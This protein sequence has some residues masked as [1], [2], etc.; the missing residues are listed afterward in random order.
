MDKATKA[1]IKQLIGKLEHIS[2]PQPVRK[3]EAT[4]NTEGESDVETGHSNN[5]IPSTAS[6]PQPQPTKTRYHITYQP[7]KDWWDKNK[8]YVE[9]GGAIL[10]AVYTFFTIKMYCANKQAADAAT[11]AAKTAA[12]ELDLSERPWIYADLA[13]SGQLVFDDPSTQAIATTLRFLVTLRNIGHSVALDVNDW[14]DIIPIPFGNSFDVALNRQRQYCDAV[15]KQNERGGDPLF[16]DQDPLKHLAVTG[17]S[18]IVMDRVRSQ[19]AGREQSMQTVMFIVVGCVDYRSTLNNLHHQT[20]FA[21]V[22]GKH[23]PDPKRPTMIGGFEPHG[24][25]EGLAIGY[26]VPGGNSVD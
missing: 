10:L 2:E 3:N 17:P 12:N 19:I 18:K 6:V 11:S 8:R 23:D 9:I 1:L 4:P 20:R 21:Y 13:V 25:V 22:L 15:R 7:E 5:S 26:P 14:E 16:P 24:I